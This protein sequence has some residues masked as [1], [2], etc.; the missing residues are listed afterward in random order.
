MIRSIGFIAV[1]VAIDLHGQNDSRIIRT[2]L[3]PECASPVSISVRGNYPHGL[4][5]FQNVGLECFAR[6]ADG[7]VIHSF[8]TVTFCG[9]DDNGTEQHNYTASLG[10]V[11]AE[12]RQ[13]L[14]GFSCK[15]PGEMRV[16]APSRPASEIAPEDERLRRVQEGMFATLSQETPE[17]QPIAKNQFIDVAVERQL[18]S[19]AQ[20][21]HFLIHVRI[22]SLAHSNVAVDL[23]G[24]DHII[25]PNMWQL[26]RAP[27]RPVIAE[28]RASPLQVDSKLVASVVADFR[29]GALT[30]VK[31][32]V[33]YYCRFLVRH[34]GGADYSGN[35]RYITISTDGE[36]SA[37]LP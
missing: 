23:R 36:L 2:T 13:A 30:P 12:Q 26:H 33:D 28:V 3:P 21:N 4:L 6:S 10:A 17:W 15:Y 22:T 8:G 25:Y 18:Y 1:F 7:S 31:D 29:A 11:S 14:A 27:E 20:L 37:I 19:Q 34:P 16:L 24:R 5:L 9:S 32:V 35:E